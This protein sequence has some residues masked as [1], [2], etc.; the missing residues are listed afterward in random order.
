MNEGVV[1]LGK[2]L[3]SGPLFT[4]SGTPVDAAT[5]IT[6][7]LV[8][9]ITNYLARFAR[10][11]LEASDL[12]KKFQA[13]SAR[14]VTERLVR[15]LIWFLGFSIA[16]GTLGIDLGALFAAGAVFAVGAGLAF[17]NVAQNIVASPKYQKHRR[18]SRWWDIARGMTSPTPAGISEKEVDVSTSCVG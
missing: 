17:Q 7:V 9:V 6:A 10:R 16:I 2:K 13:P 3:I 5:L 4:I 18:C 14:I 11:G 1:D 8:L 12:L 15:G